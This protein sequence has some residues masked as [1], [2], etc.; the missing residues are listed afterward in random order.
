MNRRVIKFLEQDSHHMEPKISKREDSHNTEPKREVSHNREP[1]IS[2]MED[3]QN[4]EPK[5]PSL[6]IGETRETK[7]TKREKKKCSYE[8]SDILISDNI[9]FVKL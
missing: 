2:K 9:D 4:K 8:D 5:I 6:S 3:F 7:E 1:K